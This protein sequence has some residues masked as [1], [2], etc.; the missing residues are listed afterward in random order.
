MKYFILKQD[1]PTKES[2]TIE[3]LREFNITR[4]T[5]VCPDVQGNVTDE[6]PYPYYTE[7]EKFEELAQL[8]SEPEP[9]I[10]LPIIL[11]EI[12][13]KTYDIKSA[14]N[15]SIGAEEI[16]K[17]PPIPPIETEGNN[18]PP[19]KAKIIWV[20][21]AGISLVLLLAGYWWTNSLRGS[22]GTGSTIDTSS[23]KL[24]EEAPKITN[25]E[26][27]FDSLL[28]I[29]EQNIEQANG[30][31]LTA[32]SLMKD[33]KD[34]ADKEK[35]KTL[36]AKFNSQITTDEAIINDPDIQK[37]NTQFKEAIKLLDEIITPNQ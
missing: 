3:E 29:G 37:R 6:Q 2:F 13:E 20:Y 18:P 10:P 32:F 26:A 28:K 8:F 1:K 15:V 33:C 36:K 17:I 22:G 31:S 23:P 19:P 34:C 7:A 35:V 16:I 12:E 27:K 24:V 30:E 5:K 14:Q 21:A 25:C 4:D 9:N 11:S